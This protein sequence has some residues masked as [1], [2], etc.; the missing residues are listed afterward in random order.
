LAARCLSTAA[1]ARTHV[2]IWKW[3]QKYSILA[4]RFRIHRIRVVKQIFVDET[5]LLRI[6]G[7]NY[8]WLWLAIEPD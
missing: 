7:Q 5:T 4:D 8:Y 3:V 1:I 2:A 6:D